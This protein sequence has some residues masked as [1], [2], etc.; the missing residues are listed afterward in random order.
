MSHLRNLTQK[1]VEWSTEYRLEEG[2][3]LRQ[4]AAKRATLDHFAC[5]IAGSVTKPSQIAQ[6]YAGVPG[7]TV[8]SAWDAG[9]EMAAFANGVAAHSVELDDTHLQSSLHPGVA[10]FP[11]ALAVA[12]RLDLSLRD[13]LEA[14]VVGYEACCKVG[15]CARPSVLYEKAFHPTAACG[16][17]GAVVAAGKLYGVGPEILGNAIG[18]AASQASGLMAF[19]DDG[20]QTKPFH[21]GWVSRSGIVAIELARL[22]YIG[23][24]GALETRNGFLRAFSDVHTAVPVEFSGNAIVETSHKPHACC[25]YNQGAIDLAIQLNERRIDPKSIRHILVE[26]VTPALSLVAEP[27]EQKIAPKTNV[28]AQ[29]SLHYGVA[30]GIM[31]G[32]ASLEEY[33]EQAFTDPAILGLASKVK[34]ASRKE[35]DTVYPRQWPTRMSVASDDGETILQTEAPKGDPSNPLSNQELLDKFMSLAL[36]RIPRAR[37]VAQLIWSDNHAAIR[38]VIDTA[39]GA[40]GPSI[41]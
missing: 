6:R 35:F 13:A 10:V 31:R 9:Q 7:L 4:E 36:P 32:K 17:F 20:S 34:C 1:L 14:A 5:L 11:A 29:F 39:R 41:K 40:P 8:A 26:T 25:R 21:A 15:E 30:V 33:E 27:R 19:L 18:I 37:E 12:E 16:V 2:D 3:L 38:Q 24:M 28:E 22:G 23:P